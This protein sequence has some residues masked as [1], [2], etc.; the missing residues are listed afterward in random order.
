MGKVHLITD[1]KIDSIMVTLNPIA[2]RHC[3]VSP[4][5]P[6]YK[7]DVCRAQLVYS[8]MDSLRHGDDFLALVLE[9]LEDG[10]DIS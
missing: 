5:K 10:T 2:K 8:Y 4:S 1:D 3:D 9:G 7:C 6:C